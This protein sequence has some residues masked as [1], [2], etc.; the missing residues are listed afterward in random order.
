MQP[1]IRK[2]GILTSGGDSP[3]MNAAIRAVVRK[4]AN[5]GVHAMGIY[6]GYKGLLDGNFV[7]LS[8][9]AVTNKIN[10]SG[11][12]LYSSRCL[13]FKTPEGMEKALVNCEKAGIDAVVAIGGDGTFAG[14]ED[15]AKH[16]ILAVGIPGT[17]DNDIVVSDYTVGFDSALN[18]TVNN[19]NCL[20]STCETHSRLSVVE[21][22]GRRCGMLTLHAAIASGAAIL[23]I[24]EFPFD[25]DEIIRKA[26]EIR[27]TGKRGMLAV[28]CEGCKKEDGTKLSES[29]ARRFKAETNIDATFEKFS[30]VVRGG[31]PTVR[32]N[33]T[34]SE[35]GAKAVEL[36]LEGE[37][38]VVIVERD[39]RIQP[40]EIHFALATQRMYRGTLTAEEK[41][42]FTPK[43]IKEMKA[44][45]ERRTDELATLYKLSRD[46]CHF[47]LTQ[48]K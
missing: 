5:E 48:M 41:K 38:S 6:E 13:E 12:F 25:E 47:H 15:L 21:T 24:P 43:Q 35:M 17:I 33:V 7:E 36:L 30:H 40:V 9:S 34:A 31:L 32:E 20:R 8:S 42:E 39:G 4:A 46:I 14:A 28:I 29:L 23:A 2:I 26:L 3:G 44:L 18:T 22:M 10:V 27:S 19:L 11:S 1:K 16:G 45:C 37:N